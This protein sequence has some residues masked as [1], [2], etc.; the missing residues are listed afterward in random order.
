[1][2]TTSLVHTTNMESLM[3]LSNTKLEAWFEA[4]GLSVRVIA[5]CGDP[6]CPDCFT[7]EPAQEAA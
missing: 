2:E 1:M 5:N 3:A 4:G 7:L 6:S